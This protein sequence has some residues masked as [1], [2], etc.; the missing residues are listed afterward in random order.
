MRRLLLALPLTLLPLLAAHAQ[1][2]DHEH[3]EHG[4][5]GKH[6]HGLASLNVA[7]DGNLLEIQ[8]ESPALN[9]VGFEHAASSDADRDRVAAARQQLGQPLAL[10]AL[11][12]E[13][14]CTLQAHELQGALFAEHEHAESA[15]H[16]QAAEQGHS[17]ID[18][19]YQFACAAP[20]ALQ[21]LELGRFFDS[22]PATEKLEVQLIGPSGQ[23]GA[24]LSPG[25][26]R[27]TF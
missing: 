9:L 23:Q 7:L 19:H 11:P 12:N 3:A 4:S 1:E 17:D 8:L 6:E 20:Q 26:S 5:L 22:F 10:F 15:G 27:L 21:S 18:A 2:H 24:I 25:N 13:A 16:A 14:Q